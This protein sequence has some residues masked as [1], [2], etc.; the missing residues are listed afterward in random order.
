MNNLLILEQGR[1]HPHF[2]QIKNAFPYDGAMLTAMSSCDN[3]VNVC[4]YNPSQDFIRTFNDSDV[5][6]SCVSDDV[7]GSLYLLLKFEQ[8]SQ[9][10]TYELPFNAALLPDQIFDTS[11]GNLFTFILTCRSSGIVKG[12]RLITFPK[13]VYADFIS[14]AINQRAKSASKIDTA[15]QNV[16]SFNAINFVQAGI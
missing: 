10:V 14:A 16:I 5:F 2:K 11:K 3:Q 15:N 6:M 9:S 13:S 1:V 7:T 4:H 8:G 12:L